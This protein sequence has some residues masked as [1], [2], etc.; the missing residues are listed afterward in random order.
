MADT[1]GDVDRVTLGDRL[2]ALQ[3]LRVA[4]IVLVVLCALLTPDL[5][6]ARRGD[7]LVATALFT[8]LVGVA[9]VVGRRRHLVD[10]VFPLAIAVDAFWLTYSSA[11][12]G[13]STSPVRYAILLHLGAV[14]LV[15]SSRL[16]LLT[17]LGQSVLLTGAFL[18]ARS[19]ALPDTDRVPVGVAGTSGQRLAIFVTV[20]WLVAL[21]TST[22]SAVNERELRRRRTDLEA[23]TAL[24]EALERSRDS[25]SVARA[26]LDAVA[27]GLGFRRGLV[28]AG[29]E[30]DLPL[31]ASLG[32]DEDTARRPGPPGPSAVVGRAYRVRET[33][34]V[35]GLDPGADPWLSRLLPGAG[36]LV[37]VPLSAEGRSIGVLVV[38]HD[39]RGGSGI[40]RRVVLALERSASYAALALRNAWLLE[41]V[42][43]LAATDGLTKIANRRTFEAT[44]EREL[45]R[46]ARSGDHVSLVMLD[47]DH[48]KMLN[49]DH[50]HP[51]GDDV[52]RRVA[53]QLSA[54]CR[55]FD[56]PARYGGEE[57]AVILPGCGPDLAGQT[58]ERLRASVS[59]GS[60]S[61]SVT[62]SAG[63]ACF[64]TQASDAGALIRAADQALYRAKSLG[65]DR[66][67]LFG[68]GEA[69]P[70]NITIQPSMPPSEAWQSSAS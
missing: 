49:D 32:L 55:D 65:R 47:I 39:S 42:Q 10:G 69:P 57:F 44:L 11:Q 12:T 34:L 58:A 62:A 43:R 7:V 27:E 9:E 54:A 51:A 1:R 60:A 4:A 30:G 20:L 59:M 5:L 50:G 13:G 36:H 31:L 61:P 37:V 14:C 3:Y 18:A 67:C 24:A 21:V 8:V 64:P 52:L 56:T 17:A 23:L 28:L 45:A 22:L 6:A 15:G 26:L 46:A 19:G 33:L 25:A 68:A 2:R 38:E 70:G 29:P 35:D 16:G 63:A 41:Q 53:S 40:A 66:T 48:F